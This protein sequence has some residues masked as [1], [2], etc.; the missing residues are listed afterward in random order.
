MELFTRYYESLHELMDVI[1]PGYRE[2]FAEDFR[3]RFDASECRRHVILFIFMAKK[4]LKKNRIFSIPTTALAAQWVIVP[5]METTIRPVEAHFP[6]HSAKRGCPSR[7]NI[8]EEEQL[9]RWRT[10]TENMEPEDEAIHKFYNKHSF[11]SCLPFL[12]QFRALFIFIIITIHIFFY[13][14]IYHSIMKNFL[15]FSF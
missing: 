11:L 5:R 9:W 13:F 3:N 4:N 14:I 12:Y 8:N 10:A 15:N 6:A 7:R 1:S 2:R